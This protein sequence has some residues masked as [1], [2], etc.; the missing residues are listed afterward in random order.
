[1]NTTT[2]KSHEPLNAGTPINTLGRHFVTPAE[3][4]F[5]RSHSNVPIV[6]PSSYR[7]TLDG[8]VNLSISLTMDDLR[9]R[10]ASREVTATL[11][12]AGNRRAELHAIKPINGEVQWGIDAISTGV[13]TGVRL[14]DVLKDAGVQSGAAHVLFDGLDTVEREGRYF[15]FGGSIPLEKALHTEVLLA[16]ALNGQPLTAEHGFP[17]RVVV[18]GYIGARSVKWLKHICVDTQPSGNF[19]QTKAYKLFPPEVSTIEADWSKGQT[20]GGLRV[21][22]VITS[23][24]AGAFLEANRPFTV[25]GY[26]IGS[27]NAVV[28]E[29]ELSL[30]EGKTWHQVELLSPSLQT[31]VWQLWKAELN[32]PPGSYTMIVRATDSAR[33]SQPTDPFSIWNFKGYMNNACPKLQINVKM[34]E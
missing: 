2:I 25:E 29:V 8:L 3:Q 6:D 5:I 26:A 7:L 18:P 14:A 13:W 4:F 12:C 34:A 16:Y 27:E 11:Q 24:V 33:E 17:L 31:G 21:N 20:L 15:G 9:A 23:P 1:M 32:L 28:N 10:F 30:D 19:F 22:S